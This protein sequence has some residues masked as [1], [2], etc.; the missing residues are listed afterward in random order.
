MIFGVSYSD[1]EVKS[2][3]EFGPHVVVEDTTNLAQIKV[4]WQ[5]RVLIC[6]QFQLGLQY[7]DKPFCSNAVLNAGLSWHSYL[8]SWKVLSLWKN[9]RT[10]HGSNESLQYINHGSNESLPGRTVVLYYELVFWCSTLTFSL[11]LKNL[12]SSW[13]DDLNANVCNVGCFLPLS[14]LRT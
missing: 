3:G 10:N 7:T 13:M 9:A 5:Y 6:L 8:E 14:V 12:W 2:T 11:V 4:R 1:D